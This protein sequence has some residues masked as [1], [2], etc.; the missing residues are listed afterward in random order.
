MQYK[1]AP[2]LLK[3][4]INMK[5]STLLI[6][7]FVIIINT[8]VNVFA[9]NKIMDPVNYPI[10]ISA[11]STQATIDYKENKTDDIVIEENYIGALT[12]DSELILKV[13]DMLFKKNIKTEIVG[14]L[15][16]DIEVKNGN[17]YIKINTESKTSP[18]KIII[19]DLTIYSESYEAGIYSLYLVANYQTELP[20]EEIIAKEDYFVAKGYEEGSFKITKKHIK[21][22]VGSEVITVNEDPK[23]I[24][25]PPY[26]SEEGYV[27]VPLRSMA[28]AIGDNATFEWN[29]EEKFLIIKFEINYGG[30]MILKL[31]VDSDVANINNAREQKMMKKIEIKDGRMFISIRDLAHLFEIKD[32]DIQ[33]NDINNEVKLYYDFHF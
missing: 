18:S 11:E 17:I 25:L 27:M 2:Y 33:W 22:T 26:I 14:D 5:K 32:K 6:L 31:K 13:N 9:N 15:K 3:R 4:R 30:Y 29:E 24:D 7:L 21:V 8:N 28:D 1:T 23:N 16:A 20:I 12:E 19:S 10:K